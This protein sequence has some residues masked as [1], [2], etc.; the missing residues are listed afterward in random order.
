MRHHIFYPLLGAVLLCAGC[1]SSPV[2]SDRR[3]GPPS[4]PVTMGGYDSKGSQPVEPVVSQRPIHMGD[5]TRQILAEA[6]ARPVWRPTIIQK[7]RVDAY[8]DEKGNAVAPSWKYVI[9]RQGGWDLD[10][11]RDTTSYV[12][13]ENSVAPYNANGVNY[14]ASAV[15]VPNQVTPVELYDL[16]SGVVKTTGLTSP[17]DEVAARAMANADETAIFDNRF[18]WVI[19]P[20]A[21]MRGMMESS[22]P[23]HQPTAAQ[24]QGMVPKS[25]ATTFQQ[26]PA[27]PTALNTNSANTQ[28]NAQGQTNS[29]ALK[30]GDLK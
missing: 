8:E 26:L 1:A 24:M 13:P 12:P 9:V 4:N 10:A 30:E 18:G 27:T 14:G 20:Q 2:T 5:T 21:V 25:Q 3:D 29:T 16:E 11:I 17:Q 19:V 6:P 22:S 7:V 23:M 28:T 15:N